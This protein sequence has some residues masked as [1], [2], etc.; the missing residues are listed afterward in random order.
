M[1]LTGFLLIVIYGVARLG[2]VL[3]LG[4]RFGLVAYSR[5]LWIG[6]REKRSQQPLVK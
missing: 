5:D 3:I 4:Q 6:T 2:P 1:G